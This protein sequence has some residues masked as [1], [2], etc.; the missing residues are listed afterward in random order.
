[1]RTL[2]VKPESPTGWSVGYLNGTTEF[3][4]DRWAARRLI[5]QHEGVEIIIFQ[6]LLGHEFIALRWQES[7]GI[8][9]H[10]IVQRMERGNRD[11]YHEVVWPHRTLEFAEVPSSTLDVID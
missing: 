9:S 10:T 5:G 2:I 1:M 8:R 4:P 7:N 11:A 3:A 6:N